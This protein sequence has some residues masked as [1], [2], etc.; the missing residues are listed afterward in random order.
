MATT[1]LYQRQ[2]N[3]PLF[4]LLLQQLGGSEGELPMAIAY[5]TQ[6]TTDNDAA[7][8]SAL[9][10][11][12]RE[13]IKHADLLGSMLLQLTKGG[14][15]PLPTHLDR[16]ELRDLL[17]N[18]GL[19]ND[20]VERA[21]VLL[22]SFIEAE[23]VQSSARY[24]AS[25]PKIYLAANIAT[26]DKQIAAYEELATLTTDSNFVSALNYAKS[27]QIDHRAEFVDLLR[28]ASTTAY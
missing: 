28:R 23:D 7:R 6:A 21:S 3:D 25:D 14:G 20:N 26:E 2:F 27:R 18:K 22:K 10:R 19:R 1:D 11:I 5:L 16:E 9:V 4:K 12:A 24:Y 13:K 15:G 8:K 17:K